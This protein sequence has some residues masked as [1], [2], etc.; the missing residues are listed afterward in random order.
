MMLLSIPN[1][2]TGYF[3]FSGKGQGTGILPFRVMGVVTV[4]V[5]GIL[6]YPIMAEP[7]TPSDLAL[8]DSA[9]ADSATLQKWLQETPN[10]FEENRHDPAFLTTFRLGYAYYPDAQGTSGIS[11]G[12]E[13]GLIR[14][15]PASISADYQ[16][17]FR[18][19][20][21]GGLRRNIIY[22]P[23]DGTSTLRHWWDTVPY[24]RMA[25]IKTA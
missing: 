25:I 8:P 13:D 19:H 1:I 16:T 20:Q 9:P 12:V 15:S 10:L 2:A 7:V 24:N 21:D 14:R 18:G 6:G 22:S 5:F 4:L 3:C 23:S 11:F 17:N